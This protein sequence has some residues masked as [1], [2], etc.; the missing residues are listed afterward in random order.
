MQKYEELNSF[1][2]GVIQRLVYWNTIKFF[3]LFL[4]EGILLYIFAQIMAPITVLYNQVW[5]VGLLACVVGFAFIYLNVSLI[6]DFVTAQGKIEFDYRYRGDRYFVL[7]VTWF[8]SFVF[9]AAAFSAVEY[10]ME[11]VLT[12]VV[13]AEVM[14]VLIITMLMAGVIVAIMIFVIDWVISIRRDETWWCDEM[15]ALFN[16]RTVDTALKEVVDD[17]RD[18]DNKKKPLLSEDSKLGDVFKGQYDR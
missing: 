10:L 1:K 9:V 8:L 18:A 15:R 12:I 16:E 14:E 5:L 4:C 7:F 3:S 13:F 11:S 2:D 17:I 6:N